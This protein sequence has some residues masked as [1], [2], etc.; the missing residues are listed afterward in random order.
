MTE[1]KIVLNRAGIQELLLSPEMER[2]VERV[3]DAVASTAEAAAGS[4][5]V[6]SS[7]GAGGVVKSKVPVQM[8]RRAHDTGEGLNDE[9]LS[10]SRARAAILVSHPTPTGREAGIRA[11]LGSLDSGSAL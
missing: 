10:R 3:A 9:P 11:L 5:T 1:V 6:T 7:D 4:H 2:A 8:L